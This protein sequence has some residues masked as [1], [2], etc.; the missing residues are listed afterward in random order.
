MKNNE[1]VNHL[2]I[3]ETLKEKF[4]KENDENLNFIRKGEIG[5]W[6]NVLNQ[7]ILGNKYNLT[8]NSWF[9]HCQLSMNW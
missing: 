2:G 5:G 4:K 9:E 1:S 3:I 6:K 8:L 7:D